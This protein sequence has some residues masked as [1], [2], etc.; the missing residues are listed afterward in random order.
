MIATTAS[1][2]LSV[3]ALC[4]LASLYRIARGPTVAD[5]VAATDLMTSCI[6]AMV[7]L[8]GIAGATRAYVDVVIALA[9][10]GF[11]GT[12]AMARYLIGGHVID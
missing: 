11:F 6:M 3:L 10:L 8:V 5:R 2:C 9:I 12:V 7:V 4:A 1:Y